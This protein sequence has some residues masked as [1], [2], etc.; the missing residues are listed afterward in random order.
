[1]TESTAPVTLGGGLLTFNAGASI[2]LDADI[3]TS[4]GDV[5]MVAS[6]GTLTMLAGTTINIGGGDGYL[7][8]TG[9]LTLAQVTTTG[10]VR[11][12]SSS[13]SILRSALNDRA[14][15]IASTLQL[16]AGLA[17]GSLAEDAGALITDVT[18][19]NA[20]AV[21]GVLAIR[22]RNDLTISDS[23]FDVSHAQ[24]NRASSSTDF[25]EDRLVQ[26]GAGNTVLRV[27]GALTVESIT[28]P[29]ATVTSAGNLLIDVTDEVTVD[30]SVEVTAG[31]LQWISGGDFTLNADLDVTGGTLLLQAGADY[32]QSA[33]AS[34]TVANAN[35]FIESDGAMT[36][37]SISAGAGDLALTA[38]A[39]ITQHSGTLLEASQ[40]RVTAGGSIATAADPLDFDTTRLS[41][42]AGGSAFLD[43]ANTLVVDTISAIEVDTVTV[44][45]AV[46]TALTVAAQ[47][48]LTTG[49]NGSVVLELTAGDLTLNGGLAG[50]AANQA[51]TTHGSGNI[52]LNLPGAL[53][54]GADISSGSGHVTVVADGAVTF[55]TTADVTTTLEGTIYVESTTSTL[56]MSDNS[57]FSTGNGDVILKANQD[58][59]LGGV[60]TTGD[61]GIVATLGSILDGGDTYRDVIADGLLL[62]AGLSIGLSSNALDLSVDSVSAVAANGGIFLKESNGLTVGDTSAAIQLVG[63]DSTT[64]A[65]SISAQSDLRTLAGNGS[66]IVEVAAGNLTLEDGTATLAGTVVSAHGTGNILLQTLDGSLSAY[67]DILTSG[68]NVSM[69]S[70]GAIALSDDVSITTELGGSLTL[71][72]ESGTITQ[73]IGGTLSAFNGDIILEA[74]GTISISGITTGGNVGIIST[75]GSI[76]DNEAARR[77]II[78]DALL[79]RAGDTIASGSNPIETAVNTVSAVA[80]DGGV[81]LL[82]L[83]AVTVTS[84]GAETLVVLA[85]DSTELKTLDTQSGLSAS[86]SGSIVL[87][88]A[89]DNI[90]V[91]AGNTVSAEVNGHILLDSAGS[92][93]INGNVSSEAG[94]VTLEAETLFS[95]ASDITVSTGALGEIV[96]LG[97]GSI[98]SAANSRFINATGNMFIASD[99]DINL[100]GVQSSGK[101]AISSVNGSI[102]AAGSDAYDREVI[103]SELLLRAPEGRA[104]GSLASEILRT[105][106]D[107]LSALSLNGVYVTSG[108]MR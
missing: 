90:T 36:L 18:L 91:A 95:L 87:R 72:S 50:D 100:G 62:N 7:S 22:E 76:L 15:L 20:T 71:I 75:N 34:V 66:I 38:G 29:G 19:L 14:N 37:G 81:F 93:I 42:L 25:I 47:S 84:T 96:I 83:D 23:T 54:A 68:G 92:L 8:A 77:N 43:S 28:N 32:T 46:G 70:T 13:G 107:R 88:N 94:N 44:L 9:N 51:V 73:N 2:D 108:L 11:V 33:D 1:V 52:L 56:T 82:E 49:N 106:V 89:S 41:V 4:G 31:S 12:Q 10:S 79:L 101:V 3:S 60:S 78:A 105:D 53:I 27:G 103:A 6:T 24:A 102:S 59:T 30:G 80:L 74:D 98:Y 63:S 45:G 85:D 65:I 58:L 17:V 104:G 40:L 5:T 99:G 69:L 64:T 57:L 86:T 55:N 97:V 21:S 35:S 39:A 16:Y 48:D 67:A 26:T 61:V